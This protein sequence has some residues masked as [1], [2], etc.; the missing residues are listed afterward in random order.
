VQDHPRQRSMRLVPADP[1]AL[2]AEFAAVQ[3]DEVAIFVGPPARA[4]ALT[5][6]LFGGPR[7][8][9]LERVRLYVRAIVA[10]RVEVSTDRLGGAAGGQVRLLLED[11][12]R[13]RHLCNALVPLRAPLWTRHRFASY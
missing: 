13:P 7:E 1:G 5:L 12:T 11:G 10:G 4:Y 8:E 2:P 3:D 9:L 6:E